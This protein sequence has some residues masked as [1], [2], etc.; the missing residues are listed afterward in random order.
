MIAEPIYVEMHGVFPE[1]SAE[2]E[3]CDE[4]PQTVNSHTPPLSPNS[5][6]PPNS[7]NPPNSADPVAKARKWLDEKGISYTM[8]SLFQ[9]KIE[10]INFYPKRGTITIDNEPAKR[11][12]KGLTGLSEVLIEYSLMHFN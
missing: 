5:P 7:H 1:E 11:P 9:I 12:Q 4:S 8:P 3:L 2:L 6:K 10:S